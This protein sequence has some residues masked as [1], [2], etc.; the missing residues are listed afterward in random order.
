[1]IKVNSLIKLHVLIALANGKTYGYELM[2]ELAQRTG[3]K[4]NPSNVYPFLRELETDGHITVKETSVRE[5]KIYSLTPSGRKLAQEV[6][7]RVDDVVEFS[8]KSKLTECSHCGCKVY[9]GKHTEKIKG[10]KLAFCCCHCA[11][12]FKKKQ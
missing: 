7:A 11:S 5:K 2:K 12:S 6:L 8:L 9:S 1:M 4:T 3:K 10:K